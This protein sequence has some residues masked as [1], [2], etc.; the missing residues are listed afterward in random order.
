M[1][2]YEIE[3]ILK[4]QT[5]KLGHKYILVK[6]KNFPPSYNSWIQKQEVGEVS[7][8]VAV[9]ETED[10]EPS[11]FISDSDVLSNVLSRRSMTAYNFQDVIIENYF[12]PSLD[13][14]ARNYL[15]VWNYKARLYVILI[16]QQK[17]SLADGVDAIKSNKSAQNLIRRYIGRKFSICTVGDQQSGEDFCGTSAVLICLEFLRMMKQG[18]ISERLLLPTGL[19]GLLSRKLHRQPTVKLNSQSRIQEIVKSLVCQYCN[20]NF[21]S[22][23]A[24]RLKM[25]EARCPKNH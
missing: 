3:E 7:A 16:Y 8:S 4:E 19:K 21:R 25:H 15:L 2:L 5:N 20:Q 1:V 18:K 17:V 14:Q 11:N 9:E 24:K 6:W 22:K 23:G 12:F 10:D 13:I